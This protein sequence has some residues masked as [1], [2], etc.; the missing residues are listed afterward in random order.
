MFMDLDCVSLHNHS[1]TNKSFIN[2]ACSF[3]IFC[4]WISAASPSIK[5]PKHT[6]SLS[7]SRHAWSVNH[8]L[9]S[10]YA[11]YKA[12]VLSHWVTADNCVEHFKILT[13][14]CIRRCLFYCLDYQH[15]WSSHWPDH[16]HH[17]HQILLDP[18]YIWGIGRKR[19][20]IFCYSFSGSM[21]FGT[22][23]KWAPDP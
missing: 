6:E 21:L 9:D 11:A 20:E 18:E 2:Q 22:F 3:K 23:K 8:I 13:C 1:N 4:L 16:H 7:K 14:N 15:H 5:T 12:P 17:H 19:F 10:H